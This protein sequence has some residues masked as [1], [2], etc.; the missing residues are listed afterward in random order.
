MSCLLL[1]YVDMSSKRL[2][3]KTVR[4]REKYSE[5]IL[6]NNC[7]NLT[8]LAES[9]QTFNEFLSCKRHTSHTVVLFY[10][11]GAFVILFSM[12]GS[13]VQEKM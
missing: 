9:S 1:S 12:S 6:H 7:W 4:V 8:I 5:Q 13:G 2:L 10:V 3:C 11:L